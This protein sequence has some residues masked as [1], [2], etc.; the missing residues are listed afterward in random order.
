MIDIN[1]RDFR[2]PLNQQQYTM[3]AL[4]QGKFET[5]YP[6][7]KV[8]VLDEGEDQRTAETEIK[9]MSEQ[10]KLAVI[11]DVDFVTDNFIQG[12]EQNAIFFLN[13]V[14]WMASGEELSSIRAKSIQTRPL[15]TTTQSEKN[16]L[17]ALNAIIV[18]VVLI[19]SGISYNVVRKRRKSLI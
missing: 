1:F 15:I 11:A 18:P 19:V 9:S 2:P 13:L 8:P 17:K 7:L 14:E 4:V 5:A 3:G 10:T 16:M 12:N 6:E